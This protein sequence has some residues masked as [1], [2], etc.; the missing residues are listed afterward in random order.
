MLAIIVGIFRVTFKMDETDPAA[1]PAKNAINV[2]MK[3]S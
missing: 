1:Q 2:E 3:G